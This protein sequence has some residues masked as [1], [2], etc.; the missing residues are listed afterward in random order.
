MAENFSMPAGYLVEG[1][2][3]I[4]VKVGDAFTSLDELEN[5]VLFNVPVDNV[6]NIKLKDI[7]KVEMVDN[8]SNMYAKINGNDGV[9]L[10]FQKQSTSSTAE[11]SDKVN[12]KIE[13]LQEK[14]SNLHITPLQD[15]GVYINIVISSVLNNLV[16]GGLLAV[17]ILFVFLKNIK[18]TIIIALSIPISLLF[19]VA[20]MYFSGVT[21]NVISLA[22]LA[23]GVGML[24]DNSIVVIENIYRLRNEG[25]G[26]K[27]AAVQGASQVAGAIVA[28][29]LTT[30]CV[31]L[32]IVFTDGLSRQLFT[33]M[34]LTI[35]YSLIAS[36]IVALTLV[37]TI[38]S[39]VLTNLDEKEHGLFDRFVNFYEG[40]LRKA[41][42]YK[43]GVLGA[44]AIL[45]VISFIGV[46]TKGMILMPEMDSLQ[47][48]VT[49]SMEKDTSQSDLREMSNK[50]IERI[51][52]IDDVETV[53]AMES[54]A[55][56]LM[57]GQSKSISY[58]VLLNEDKKATSKEVSKEIAEK[59][60]D[61]KCE[62]KI[63]SS[64]MDMSA[65]GGS[66][67]EVK[68]K[69]DNL[70]TLKSMAKD[71]AVILESVEGTKEIQNG[72]DEGSMETKITVDKN[73]AMEHGLTVAQ[74]YQD[75]ASAI[76][77]ESNSTTLNLNSKEYP[78]V[79]VNDDAVTMSMEKDTPQSDLREMSNKVIERITEIDDV[80]TVGAMESGTGSSMG[81]QSKSISYYVL[82]NE[83]KKATSKELSKEIAEKTKDL[84]CELKINSSTMDMSA[85]GGSGVEVKIKG[86]NLDTL[87]SMAKDIAGILESVEGTKEIQNGLDESS[88]ETKITVDKNK[89]MEYGLTVA[90]V[91]QD[92]ASAIKSESNSTTLN[93]NSKEYPV[94]LVNDDAKSLTKEKLNNYE[95][96]STV[97]GEEKKI[98]LTDI[99]VISEEESLSS[100]NRENQVRNISVKAGV[101]S[102]HNVGLVSD[103]VEKKLSTYN[104]P[105]G[106]TVEMGGEKESMDSTYSDLVSMLLLAIVFIYAIMV[107]Q[108]QSFLSPFIVLFT[109]PLAFTGGL[110]ALL[111]TGFNLSMIAML[112]FL[113][114]AG[115]VVNNGIVF[116]DYVN[117]LRLEG[118]DKKEA[119]IVAGRTRIRPI[120]MTALTT[121][122]GLS[123]LAMGIGMGSDMIQPMA[124][125]TIGGL[126]YA[127]ILTLFVV[128]IIYDILHKK[129]LKPIEVD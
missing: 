65:L 94:V 56:S 39:K 53:G 2:E 16:L 115:V 114:L 13:Q 29:T 98:K 9:I 36:L 40:L 14:D 106:Y 55:G 111:L 116:V 122:L 58:Y 68:I 50:V 124:I 92:I 38:S 76:K 19:A 100:I 4:L 23:L 97:N 27:K 87:K 78:V 109:I 21:M 63:N 72:L 35:A 26:I 7:A 30:I 37:P 93:L 108:F 79:L 3:Q 90:Q 81:G 46:M 117:Q 64:T 18:P 126:T 102:D 49:M 95:I 89:A 61:L 28:S 110:L 83:D 52:E 54:G 33:D 80:E 84:N 123:T 127:T 15:Q 129:E 25:M 41:L 20:M 57:G 113:V 31:F 22:G 103:D 51:T 105:E 119:L 121:I 112:G 59:T 99:A 85:L 70:D 118:V 42:R 91:Y 120:L 77:S 48:S 11:V 62:L 32:P 96:I 17:V 125:V 67:V 44:V 45:L 101:D 66:G 43:W 104:V 75:I 128:P 60:K 73:K 8:S 107:A 69:G 34:G 47:I 71:I 12:E 6:G 82:L 24:V 1:D 5:L 10:A 88:M 86:D 74:V